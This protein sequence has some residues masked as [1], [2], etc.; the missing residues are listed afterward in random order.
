[1]DVVLEAGRWVRL[2]VV[3]D[4]LDRHH[5]L[6][7]V[8]GLLR[9]AAMAKSN[10]DDTRHTPGSDQETGGP[11]FLSKL[12]SFGSHLSFLATHGLPG[13]FQAALQ[14]LPHLA[15]SARAELEAVPS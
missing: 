2:L 8:T 13:S 6:A 3:G 10:L 11:A 5:R 9:R 7:G 4:M 14:G 15:Q 12:S 1:V